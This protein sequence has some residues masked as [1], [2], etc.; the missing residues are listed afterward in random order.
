MEP[1]LVDVQ[2]ASRIRWGAIWAGLFVIAGVQILMQLFGLS[3][4]VSALRPGH[5]GLAGGVSLWTGI[6]AII[7]TLS[8]FYFGAWFAGTLVAGTR[9]EAVLHA[10]LVWAFALTAG[11]V[12]VASG[13]AGAIELAVTLLTPSGLRPPMSSGYTIGAAWATF[14]TVLLALGVAVGGGLVASSREERRVRRRAGVVAPTV[15]TPA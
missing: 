5:A 4:G 10:I 3:I 13:V 8:A 2:V 9:R 7:S 1:E 12:L 14:G 15:T 6:W 11:I